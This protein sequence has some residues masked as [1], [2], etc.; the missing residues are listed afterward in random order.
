MN[1]EFVFPHAKAV[2]AVR[3]KAQQSTY[4]MILSDLSSVIMANA[5]EARI[6]FTFKF[7]TGTYEKQFIDNIAQQLDSFLV[8]KG[9]KAKCFYNLAVDNNY[10]KVEIDN[11]P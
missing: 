4:E 2:L 1:P 10:I 3:Q 7:Q 9:Y 5:A 8:T 6:Y 11:S